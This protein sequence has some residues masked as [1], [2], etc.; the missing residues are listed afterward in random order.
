MVP[1]SSGSECLAAVED[2]MVAA[3]PHSPGPPAKAVLMSQI[4]TNVIEDRE[5]LKKNGEGPIPRAKFC[6]L[7]HSQLKRSGQCFPLRPKSF[8]RHLRESST[9]TPLH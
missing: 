2:M 7:L 6:R 4:I 9:L 1:C 5:Y 3:Y 8:G